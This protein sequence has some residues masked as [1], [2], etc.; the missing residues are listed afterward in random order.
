M[1][2]T[3]PSGPARRTD[4]LPSGDEMVPI[5][6]APDAIRAHLLCALLNSRGV[7]AN[8]VGEHTAAFGPLGGN[9]S[10]SV[11]IR[12]ADYASGVAVLDAFLSERAEDPSVPQP[13]RCL[14]CDYDLRGLELLGD[15]VCPEC[16]IN[17]GAASRVRQWIQLARPPRDSQRSADD[18]VQAIGVTLG[19]LVLWA[20]MAAVLA[21]LAWLAWFAVS[22]RP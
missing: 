15:V 1:S 5:A 17:T 14:V 6:F 18:A 19:R 4:E 7:E 2:E 22:A 10:V 20:L 3:T 9:A 21:L 16:G 8:V 13:R 12:R 11:Q